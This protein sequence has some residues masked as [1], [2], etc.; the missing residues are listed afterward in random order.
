MIFFIIIRIDNVN[1]VFFSFI[2]KFINYFDINDQS[3]QV[4]KNYIFIFSN[5]FFCFFDIYNTNFHKTQKNNK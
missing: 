2:I 3:F 5:I 1:Q 4:L